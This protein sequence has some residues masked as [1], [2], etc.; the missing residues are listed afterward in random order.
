MVDDKKDVPKIEESGKVPIL[1]NT[2]LEYASAARCVRSQ[3]IP[4]I[5]YQ[6]KAKKT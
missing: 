6:T 2:N 1:Q 5:K 4:L 3:N